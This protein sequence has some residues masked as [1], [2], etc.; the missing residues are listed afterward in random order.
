MIR[1]T[2]TWTNPAIASEIAEH[3]E[4]NISGN[5]FLDLSMTDLRMWDHFIAHEIYS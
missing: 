4:R 1:R 2:L 3:I 5:D